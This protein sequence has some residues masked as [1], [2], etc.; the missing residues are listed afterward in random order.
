MHDNWHGSELHDFPAGV[1]SSL[2]LLG[3]TRGSKKCTLSGN[4]CE[5]FNTSTSQ[6]FP[7]NFF[8]SLYPF[9]YWYYYYFNTIGI[10]II[11]IIIKLAFLLP[12]F[13]PSLPISFPFCLPLCTSK[14][15]RT[16]P[17]CLVNSHPKSLPVTVV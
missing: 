2:L 4:F 13:F 5:Y 8:K 9:G 10:I 7:G 12:S 6:R 17:P 11:I 16:E 14:R 1:L 3:H 15:K